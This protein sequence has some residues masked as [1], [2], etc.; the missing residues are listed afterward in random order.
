MP[1]GAASGSVVVD[2][3]A[4]STVVAVDSVAAGP[5]VDSAVSAAGAVATVVE[6]DVAEGRVLELEAFLVED[7][8]DPTD[9][10]VFRQVE[11]PADFADRRESSVGG[12]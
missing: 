10:S 3:V 5:G 9:E 1:V 8:G 6:S 2:S 11:E 7:D 4:A 12:C